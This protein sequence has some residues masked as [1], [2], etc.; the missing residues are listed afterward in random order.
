MDVTNF[1]DLLYYLRDG[2][3]DQIEAKCSANSIGKSALETI[4][5]FSNE[6]GLDGGVLILALRNRMREQGIS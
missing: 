2:E 3:S 4:S 1:N 6:P 5:A